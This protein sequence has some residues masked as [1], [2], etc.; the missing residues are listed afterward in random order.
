M[1]RALACIRARKYFYFAD[2]PSSVQTYTNRRNRVVER[3]RG[4]EIYGSFAAYLAVKDKAWNVGTV[5]NCTS[6]KEFISDAKYLLRCSSSKISSSTKVY[7]PLQFDIS[8]RQYLYHCHVIHIIHF[9]KNL[10]LS[11][12]FFLFLFFIRIL[13]VRTILNKSCIIE[14]YELR[15]SIHL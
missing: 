2:A 11:F 15:R 6:R 1:R 5:A 12:S 4:I 10:L 13:Y 8:Y 14:M 7:N 9:H 3:E